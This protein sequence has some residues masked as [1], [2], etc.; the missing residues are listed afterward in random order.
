[1]LNIK[2][3]AIGGQMRPIH[4]GF[5][6]LGEWCDL[7]GISLQELSKVGDN[8]SLTSAIQL[9]YCGL[10]HGSR[11]QK[12]DFNY[13]CNDVADW[14]DEEGMDIFNDAMEIF[15]ESLAKLTPGEEKK[16]KAKKK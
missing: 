1:M 9:I 8:L 2:T 3:I 11:R 4:Y 16:K 12:K 14:I 10:K 7:S 6:A 5:A 13:S 15:T